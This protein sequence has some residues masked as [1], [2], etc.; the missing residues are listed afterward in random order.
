MH[1]TQPGV[2][3]A[4]SAKRFVQSLAALFL[5]TLLAAC[6][7]G[8]DSITNTAGAGATSARF[9]TGSSTSTNTRACRRNPAS[10]AP[11]P[12]S[13]ASSTSASTQPIPPN[14]TNA[15]PI[16]VNAGAAN[17]ANIPN[18][19]VTVCKPGTSTCQTINN[20]QLDTGSYGLRLIAGAAQQILGNLPVSVPE[21]GGQFAECA[22][23][24][25]GFT[26]GTVRLADVK[27]GSEVA[28]SIPVQIIGDLAAS[29]IPAT[30]CV[31]GVEERTAS[32]LGANGI[33]GIG[34]ATYDCGTNCFTAANSMY[35]RCQSGGKNCTQVSAPLTQQVVNPV[36]R[37]PVDNNG[38]IVQMPGIP[39]GGQA[40]ASGTLVFGIGTQSNNARANVTK[41][42]TD[43]NGNLSG[44]YKGTSLRTYFDSGSNGTYFVDSSIADCT[45][46]VF[47]CPKSAL[48]LSAKVTADDGTAAATVTFSVANASTLLGGSNFALNN[49]A[50]N[51]DGSS[52]FDFGMPFFYGRHVYVG[53]DLPGNPPYVAF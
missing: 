19:S 49:L 37:F 42:A 40:S 16:T 9:T 12:A 13:S 44:V 30:G 3:S 46:S 17:Y 34:A 45:T 26:W 14:G 10:C 28:S 11:A 52:Y 29:T 27:M 5:V 22:H 48:S 43:G 47:Y 1:A 33:L 2:I 53:F 51:F 20:I 50:G 23:F 41:L 18:V 8:G 4:S 15:V 6:G 21:G 32:D 7:D 35:F 31:T 36:T 38:V 25:S 24:A 39:T